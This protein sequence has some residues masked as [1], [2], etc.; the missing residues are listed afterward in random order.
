MISIIIT[1]IMIWFPGCEWSH[2]S[3][4]SFKVPAGSLDPP[5]LVEP[6]A[7][8][9]NPLNLSRHILGF[10]YIDDHLEETQIKAYDSD[11][12]FQ[13]WQ[14][15]KLTNLRRHTTRPNT[16]RFSFRPYI[17]FVLMHTSTLFFCRP[18]VSWTDLRTDVPG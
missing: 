15:S 3:S 10:S 1:I 13:V 2:Q 4:E 18:K 16:L 11:T 17:N 12:R 6:T 7:L 9:W 8:S 14:I 5:S